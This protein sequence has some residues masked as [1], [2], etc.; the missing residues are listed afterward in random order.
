MKKPKKSAKG[1]RVPQLRHNDTSISVAAR[2]VRPGILAM[3][4]MTLWWLICISAASSILV[5]WCD[6]YLPHWLAIPLGIISGVVVGSVCAYI[7]VQGIASGASTLLEVNVSC[8]ILLVLVGILFPIFGKAR[9]KARQTNCKSTLKRI[10][11]AMLMYAQDNDDTLPPAN[12]WIDTLA[13][14]DTPSGK[15]EKPEDRYHCVSASG[16]EMEVYGY[17]YNSNAASQNLTKIKERE[18]KMLVYDSTTLTRNAFDTGTSLPKEGRHTNGNNIAFV[19]G[20]VRWISN[21]E[22]DSEASLEDRP[23]FTP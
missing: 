21:G 15:S 5:T 19:D 2:E 6:S 4:P 7:A 8:C 10:S 12:N 17:T 9:E 14:Y 18:A 23:N 3:L 13:P 1:A 16:K 11:A 20:H 22:E